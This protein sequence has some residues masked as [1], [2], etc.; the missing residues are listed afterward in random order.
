MEIAAIEAYLDRHN[1]DARPFIW[2][3]PAAETCAI[4][5]KWDCK[6]FYRIVRLFG[7]KIPP[8]VCTL[9]GGA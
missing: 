9:S 5:K 1:A 7:R 8:K 2:T 6:T 4:L 3:A